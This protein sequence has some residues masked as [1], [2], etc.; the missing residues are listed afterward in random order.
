[1]DDETVYNKK[2]KTLQGNIGPSDVGVESILQTT[3]EMPELI[4]HIVHPV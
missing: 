1:M 4:A 2:Y 3:M